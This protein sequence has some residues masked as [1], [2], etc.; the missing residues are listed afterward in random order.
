MGGFLESLR[1]QA[2]HWN[3][4]TVWTITH[5]WEPEEVEWQHAGSVDSSARFITLKIH[6]P[7]EV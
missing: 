5:I 7:D 4:F 6:L 2:V 3:C 1:K